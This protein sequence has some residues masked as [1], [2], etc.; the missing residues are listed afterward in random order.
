[1]LATLK[2]T[3]TPFL[4]RAAVQ[5]LFRLQRRQAGYL[6]KK[7]GPAEYRVGKAFVVRRHAVV[8]LLE[9]KRNGKPYKAEELRQRSLREAL[10]EARREQKARSVRFKIA[11][12][13]PRKMAGLP[14]QVRLAPGELRVTFATTE[15]LLQLL[16]DLSRAIAHDFPT[17]ETLSQ[18]SG[19]A[20]PES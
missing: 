8:T 20:S 14:D 13:P 17:F 11:P 9:A 10:D 15:E 19:P 5:T 3:T 18:G 16:Y 2:K 4:D 7:L 6:M 12:E 1:M